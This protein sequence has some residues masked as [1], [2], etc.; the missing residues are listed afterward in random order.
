MKPYFDVLV[1]KEYEV[2]KDGKPIQCKAWN[3]IGRAWKSRSERSLN[4]EL[5][6]LPGHR[7]VIPLVESESKNQEPKH[8]T[9]NFDQ[10]ENIPF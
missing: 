5:Y 3:R 4:L 1:L 10:F 7:Y 6:L 9:V 2:V 8:E